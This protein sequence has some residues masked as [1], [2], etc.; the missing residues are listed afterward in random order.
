MMTPTILADFTLTKPVAIGI[1]V[2]VLVLLFLAFK[3]AKFV[4]KLV[5]VL[6]V[7]GTIALAIWWFYF[8]HPS[9]F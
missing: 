2:A 4:M 3:A 7:L 5:L 8:G 9:P 6:A 1:G